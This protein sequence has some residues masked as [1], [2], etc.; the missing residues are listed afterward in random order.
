LNI[1]GDVDAS[2]GPIESA[3]DVVIGGTVRET[4]R[5]K[6]GGK[7]P[8]SA[9]ASRPGRVEAAGD[10][11]IKGGITTQHRGMVTAAAPST[12]SIAMRPT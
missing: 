2:T 9:A 3:T 11:R 12:P 8:P 4:L 7:H 1:P 6:S 10:I 5:V